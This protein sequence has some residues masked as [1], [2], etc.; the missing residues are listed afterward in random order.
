MNIAINEAKRNVMVEGL[1][2]EHQPSLQATIKKKQAQMR[3]PVWPREK[4]RH[5]RELDEALPG[6]HM[7]KVYNNCKKR[8]ARVL[9]QLRT[10]ASQ[11]NGYLFKIKKSNT[12]R[13]EHCDAADESVHHF[14][15]QCPAWAQLRQ[16]LLGP[17]KLFTYK[18]P[19]S[20]ALGGLK[21]EE[22]QCRGKWRPSQPNYGP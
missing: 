4:A 6:E 9:V 5:L 15:L 13:C 20:T 17:H 10:G 22:G 1:R 14:I 12:P 16:E 21:T 3:R 8:E 7:V 11:L 19:A 18:H 2:W